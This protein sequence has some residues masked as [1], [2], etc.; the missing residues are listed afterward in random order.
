MRKKKHSS[1]AITHNAV[2]CQK[3]F[4]LNQLGLLVCTVSQCHLFYA[5]YILTHDTAPAITNHATHDYCHRMS[6]SFSRSK[7]YLGNVQKCK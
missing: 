7:S 4:V 1:D 5:D 6:L 2:A 3:L